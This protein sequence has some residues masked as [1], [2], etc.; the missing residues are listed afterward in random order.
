MR[1][2]SPQDLIW[3]QVDEMMAQGKE[4]TGP[5][6]LLASVT[7][8][9]TGI[10]PH[11]D[12]EA[13]FSKTTLTD[14]AQAS[15]CTVDL[16]ITNLHSRVRVVGWT[17]REVEAALR[18]LDAAEAEY[19]DKMSRTA[20]DFV[21]SEGQQEPHFR[22]QRSRETIDVELFERGMNPLC[23]LMMVEWDPTSRFYRSI[24]KERV[25]LEYSSI[26]RLMWV[27]PL[28]F[29]YTEEKNNPINWL[30]KQEAMPHPDASLPRMG[31]TEKWIEE[32][33]D[34]DKSRQVAA[35]TTRAN[36]PRKPVKPGEDKDGAP[37]KS[38]VAPRPFDERIKD[39]SDSDDSSIFEP[40]QAP[41]R[42]VCALTDTKGRQWSRIMGATLEA[43]D[44]ASEL[45]KRALS[46]EI[47]I[48][49]AYVHTV[50]LRNEAYRP[51]RGKHA[52]VF[53]EDDWPN[54]FRI[55]PKQYGA[56]TRFSKK[57][58]QNVL[59]AEFILNM[60]LRG[61]ENLFE[62]PTMHKRAYFEIVCFDVRRDSFEGGLQV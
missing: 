4:P 38:I 59:D 44:S 29:H 55:R 21:D 50:S 58:S 36:Q 32:V 7:G 48:G 26:K 40:L 45:H 2:V 6:P 9:K 20:Y 61:G 17:E 54:V 19:L 31:R 8:F 41:S 30:N 18:L 28:E 15:S 52:Q 47:C 51:Q 39:E 12:M 60:K 33:N 1:D 16:D 62:P 46:F 24:R 3:R 34:P 53:K 27:K 14:I 13:A 10:F 57:L 25:P 22:F 35:E 42:A 5:K 11:R 49:K 56:H 37:R 43:L 23:E